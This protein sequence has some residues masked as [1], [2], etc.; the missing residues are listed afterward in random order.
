[1]L[2]QD[3][4]DFLLVVE[5]KNKYVVL[6][7]KNMVI[8]NE[9]GNKLIGFINEKISEKKYLCNTDLYYKDRDDKNFMVELINDIVVYVKSEMIKMCL[10]DYDKSDCFSMH[11]YPKIVDNKWLNGVIRESRQIMVAEY[12]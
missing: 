1:M 6:D 2:D 10:G 12:F 3:Y 7:E 8:M 11:C 5:E 9:F 4:I